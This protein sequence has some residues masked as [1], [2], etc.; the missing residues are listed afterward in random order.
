MP[1]QPYKARQTDAVSEDSRSPCMSF[2]EHSPH[3]DGCSV[4]S[5]HDSN[6]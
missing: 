6:S 5:R 4:A 2:Q 1:R 3:A